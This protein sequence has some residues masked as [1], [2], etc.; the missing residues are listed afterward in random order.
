MTNPLVSLGQLGQSPWYDFI[1]RD[2]VRSGEL[3]RL[4]REDGLLGMTSNPTIFEK[5]IAGSKDYDADIARLTAEGKGAAEVF[6]ALAVADVQAAC[7]LF[8]PVWDARK[9]GD[10]TVS[11]EVSPTLAH[12]T[13]GTITPFGILASEPTKVFL[14]RHHLATRDSIASLA[15]ENLLYA[16]S[17]V[18]MVAVGFVVLLATVP[19]SQGWRGS[20][21]AALA[22]LDAGAPVY[23]VALGSPQ[24]DIE[25]Q[26][27]LATIDHYGHHK[28]RTDAALGDSMK[29][30][31][32]RLK[33]CGV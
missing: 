24:A 16:L 17:V 5:A 11:L 26:V 31:Y 32:T 20:L 14:T 6:E 29:R 18:A 30:M 10:G 4:I 23:Q 21:I 22:A 13:A 19:L 15:V 12:D 27:I 3:A 25:K 1:T 8:R 9:T 33:D 28:E 2:L 7:D